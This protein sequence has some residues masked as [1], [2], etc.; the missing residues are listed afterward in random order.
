MQVD[1]AFPSTSNSAFRPIPYKP[2]I[3]LVNVET[4]TDPVLVLPSC[5]EDPRAT[6]LREEAMLRKI[7]QAEVN[8]KVLEQRKKY[9]AQTKATQRAKEIRKAI[10]LSQKPDKD[11]HK[12]KMIRTSGPPGVSCNLSLPS[13]YFTPPSSA[14]AALEKMTLQE[15]DMS[16][17]PTPGYNVS[18][19]V[20]D[21]L[22][23]SDNEESKN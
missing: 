9:A 13:S 23:D 3:R 7:K 22:L 18:S 11:V 4:Q 15:Q 17:P 20:E 14:E 6:V 21:I 8:K 5:S 16:R 10:L 1:D 19:K 12:P 2:K